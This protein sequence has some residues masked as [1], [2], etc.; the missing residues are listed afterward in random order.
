MNISLVTYSIYQQIY[1]RN[2][3]VCSAG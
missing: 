2:M 1:P 3:E